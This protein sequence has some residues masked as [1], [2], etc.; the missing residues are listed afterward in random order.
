MHLQMPGRALQY[1]QRDNCFATGL[2]FY[3]IA[4]G[5]TIRVGEPDAFLVGFAGPP[6]LFR[7]RP[8]DVFVLPS[9]IRPDMRGSELD[10][11][12]GTGTQVD[13]MGARVYVDTFTGEI[14][15]QRPLCQQTCIPDQ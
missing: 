8:V 5:D 1:T 11:C 9:R 3:S 14:L 13:C 12:A 2:G 6:S 7:V 4:I 15:Q 10:C